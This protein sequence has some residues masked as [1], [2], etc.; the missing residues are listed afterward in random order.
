MKR[1]IE[2]A[3]TAIQSFGALQKEAELAG[4]LA[5]VMDLAPQVVVE[6]GADVGGTL[7]AWQQIGARRVIGV[8]LPNAKFSSGCYAL[9]KSNELD[10]H[11]SEVVY[12][13]SHDEATALQLRDLLDG[14]EVDM[15]F[16]DGDHSYDGVEQDFYMYGPMVRPGG[17]IG[18]H[19]ICNHGR[20]DVQVDQWWASLRIPKEEIITEP[21]TWGGIGVVRV[22]QLVAVP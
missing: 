6:I 8:D 2:I 17:I 11:G 3:R 10:P 12:G 7:Y 22:P 21:T 4:F 1:P 13:D 20:P 9:R 19:D 18:C 16:I 15:L 5:L 14:D